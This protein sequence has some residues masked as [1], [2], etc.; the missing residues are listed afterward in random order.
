MAIR[1]YG[2]LLQVYPDHAYNKTL[3]F[4]YGGN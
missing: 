4:N 1:E 3:V 2:S